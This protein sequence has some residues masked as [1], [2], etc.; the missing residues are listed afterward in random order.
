MTPPTC[1]V[2][3]PAAPPPRPSNPD[4]KT[5]CAPRTTRS[6]RPT[7][8]TRRSFGV[9]ID[10]SG[11]LAGGSVS[12]TDASISASTSEPTPATRTSQVRRQS[13]IHPPSRAGARA[14]R[15][16]RPT[17]AP[18]A[19]GASSSTR[20]DTG[21]ERVGV[22]GSTTVRCNNSALRVVVVHPIHPSAGLHPPKHAPQRLDRP[23][24][25]QRAIPQQRAV[26]APQSD[27][28]VD[29]QVE[30]RLGALANERSAWR[31]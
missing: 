4:D 11:G 1:A 23:E 28:G 5:R 31:E 25:P 17:S 14:A 9:R 2:V 19:P 16:S 22:S 24:H 7:M 30:S 6:P 3:R 13:P 10:R 15:S 21:C 8:F 18:S 20:S 12:P 26:L 29:H 27:V